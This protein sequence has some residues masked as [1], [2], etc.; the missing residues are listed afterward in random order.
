MGRPRQSNAVKEAKGTQKCRLN[1]PEPE[2]PPGIGEAPVHLGQDA[3]EA[4]DKVAVLAPANVL[5][6]ADRIAV[7]LIAQTYIELRECRRLVRDEGMTI[8]E[9][10]GKGDDAYTV[11]KAHP[12]L[13][14]MT[15]L[16]KQL[17]DM[18]GKFGMTASGRASLSVGDSKAVDA[19]L[20]FM[21]DGGKPKGG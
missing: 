18:L 19:L 6:Q 7:E 3:A 12:I 16:Q 2:S 17:V 10:R 1:P 21:R 5:T 8:Q 4:W 11:R 20:E 9:E 13:T 14:T 15:T